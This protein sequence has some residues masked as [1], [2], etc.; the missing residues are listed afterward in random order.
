[1]RIESTA[2]LK[3]FAFMNPSFISIYKSVQREENRSAR[4]GR[5]RSAEL[6]WCNLSF[7]EG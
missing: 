5:I 2:A 6:G 1:M 3:S 7:Q 4:V